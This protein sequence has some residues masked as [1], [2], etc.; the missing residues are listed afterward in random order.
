[1][2]NPQAVFF[3][4]GIL[5]ALCNKSEQKIADAAIDRVA[6]LPH[7]SRHMITP[8]MVELF[9]RFKKV[10]SPNDIQKNL[11]Q[12]AIT[13]LPVDAK[14]EL[15]IYNSFCSM[16][17][18]SEFDYADYYLCRAALMFKHSLILT[19][20]RDDLPLALWRAQEHT[21]S[22]VLPQLLPLS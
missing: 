20:D 2:S 22:H 9:Y 12:L 3:D 13:F 11:D 7:A 18:K 15:E 4:T 1:M 10:I 19:I 8:C 17:Y 6:K 14:R 16:T 5:I 21:A